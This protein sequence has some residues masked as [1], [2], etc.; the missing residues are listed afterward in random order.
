MPFRWTLVASLLFTAFGVY[1]A[2]A[3]ELIGPQAL[4]R[5]WFDGRTV[6]TVG[7]RGGK[8]E[9]SF[10]ADGTLT[11]VGGRQGSATTGTWRLDEDGFCMTLGEGK[12]E[13]CY[14][15]IRG[16]GDAIKVMRRAAAFTWTR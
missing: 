16:E 10:K 5:D 7:P 14:L 2:S 6:S 11:R 3:A 4:K 13:S 15:A 1:G 12:R 9:F 8:S